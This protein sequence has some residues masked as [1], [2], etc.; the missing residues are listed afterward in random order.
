MMEQELGSG[1]SEVVLLDGTRLPG[2]FPVECRWVTEHLAMGG[3][4]GTAGNVAVLSGARITHVINLQQEFDDSPLLRETGI[5]LRWLGV[6]E[7]LNPFPVEAIRDAIGFFREASLR[8]DHRVY[9]HCMAG[10]NRS[11]VFIYALLRATG[12][13][14][15]AAAA[16]I[17]RADPAALLRSGTLGAVERCLSR[18]GVGGSGEPVFS[19]DSAETE[20]E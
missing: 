3:M 9:V 15:A 13:T 8:R 5:V 12:W 17:G 16:A 20:G 11:P 6:P 19:T 10:R 2:G 18:F 1:E 14:G 4:I 7:S